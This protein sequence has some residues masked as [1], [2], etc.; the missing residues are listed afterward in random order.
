VR[1]SREDLERV[2]SPLVE[3]T[4]QVTRGAVESAGLRPADIDQVILVGGSTR[5]PL[6]A[7]S[8]R[9]F[10][11][12]D[13]TQ[14][15][16]PDE[17]IA[18]GAAIQAHALN[19]DKARRPNV[20]FGSRSDAPKRA[21]RA[22]LAGGGTQPPRSKGTV[23]P[24]GAVA[25]PAALAPAQSFANRGVAVPIG[26]MI[27]TGA[28]APP[29]AAGGTRT[30]QTLVE[31]TAKTVRRRDPRAEE[32]EEDAPGTASPLRAHVQK[33][34]GVA[35]PIAP[36]A[37]VLD[38]F[39]LPVIGKDY[40]KAARGADDAKKSA[41]AGAQAGPVLAAP[42]KSAKLHAPPPLPKRRAEAALEPS[43]A[44]PQPAAAS[45]QVA[46]ISHAHSAPPPNF[47]MALPR[48]AP[49]LSFEIDDEDGDAR[50]YPETARAGAAG[51]GTIA[52][53]A[54][55]SAQHLSATAAPDGLALDPRAMDAMDAMDAAA[56]S[57]LPL[58]PMESED[59]GPRVLA[60]RKDGLVATRARGT[61]LIDVTPL[62]LRVE[63]V[64]GYSD[65]L[66][67]ANTPVPC[68]RSRNFLTASDLQTR[69]VVRVAQGEH[70]KFA[71]NTY[72]GEVELT[73]L[74]EAQ[75]GQVKIAVTFELDADGSLNVR[76]KEDGTTRQ[77]TARINLL[78]S[79]SD[80]A[81]MDRM[82]EKQR[83]HA[84]VG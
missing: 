63:T 54:L 17:A 16:N 82:L 68:E 35:Q 36:A 40:S 15:I 9:A 21:T 55:D 10:F 84:V 43:D 65:R 7:Q 18:L 27:P 26:T 22:G 44:P 2:A 75:R 74:R 57:L 60:T 39:G 31:R 41:D 23:I 71:D 30:A 64:G 47:D 73:G 58:S 51:P 83:S 45:A 14:S 46:T 81:E 56:P 19:K 72:L 4:I 33:P 38:V 29:S 13:T 53:V 78:G 3:R 37:P 6:V 66:I 11:G 8:V 52:G 28:V 59:S 76:A 34:V 24:S 5:M 62:S 12:K 61:L 49:T 1:L 77:A 32:P 79:S 67:A 50:L 80:A 70:T 69:V 25:P 20:V 48:R 42:A